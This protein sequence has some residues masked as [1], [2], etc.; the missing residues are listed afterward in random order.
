M[1]EDF[2]VLLSNSDT[3]LG[4]SFFQS[5]S[6]GPRPVFREI[7]NEELEVDEEGTLSKGVTW[8]RDLS[9]LPP[10]SHDLLYSYLV[11]GTISV[12]N[13]RRGAIKHKILGYQLYKENFVKKTKS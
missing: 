2:N 10:V 6:V 13:R 3:D 9:L 7:T 8:T 11:E 12:D 1:D 5:S 4:P